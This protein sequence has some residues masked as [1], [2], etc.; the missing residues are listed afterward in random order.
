MRYKL[1]KKIIISGKIKAETGLAI[2][3]SNTAMGIGGIDKGVIRNPVTQQPYIPGSTLKGKMRSLLELNYGEIGEKPMGAVKNGPCE[4]DGARSAKL[5]GTASSTE[6]EDRE[7]KKGYQHAS[8]I[9]VRDAFLSEKQE[10][11]KDIGDFFKGTDLLYTEVK[12]EVVIDRITSK[13]MPRQL[14]RVPAGAT[15]DFEL[16]VN[17]FEAKNNEGN[18]IDKDDEAKMMQDVFSA[19]QMVQN[20]YIGGSG[21]RGSG[22]VSFNIE[23][24]KERTDA[25]YCGTAAEN[26][27]T[28]TYKSKFPK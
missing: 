21:T 20:D 10:G 9:I 6:F 25:F 28:E 17:F 13:A 1:L 26:D 4:N 15:F 5:F 22:Q 27:L 18:V 8:R 3:G 24:I 7:R 16:V 19:L 11:N 23:K 14:E 2:G 12:T